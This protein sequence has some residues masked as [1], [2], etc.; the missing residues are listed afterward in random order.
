[1]LLQGNSWEPVLF[2]GVRCCRRDM[3]AL[4]HN[5]APAV[6]KS[7]RSFVAAAASL[8]HRLCV[9]RHHGVR[10]HVA[11]SLGAGVVLI[12]APPVRE[13]PAGHAEVAGAVLPLRQVHTA[14][15]ERV[16]QLN[17][18]CGQGVAV[19]LV[20]GINDG[21]GDLEGNLRT[22]H[23]V[24]VLGGQLGIRPNLLE[25]VQNGGIE[26]RPVVR[27][28]VEAPP[29]AL[30]VLAQIGVAGLEMIH[31]INHAQIARVVHA[32]HDVDA[33][34]DDGVVQNN[35]GHALEVGVVSALV[36]ENTNVSNIHGV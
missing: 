2:L 28:G 20:V 11:G 26:L 8:G 5:D 30:V 33:P 35:V 3:I 16:V 6:C 1:M 13:R 18:D 22:V 17:A 36:E 25:G 34:Q 15:P 14:Q 31:G 19:G 29:E 24:R 27:V 12:H 23:G 4:L 7:R 32:L 9:Q 21:I 10:Q